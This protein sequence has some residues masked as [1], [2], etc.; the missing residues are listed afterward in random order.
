MAHLM[1]GSAT[2]VAGNAV[3]K[4]QP[5]GR[6]GNSG[7]TLEPHLHIGAKKNGAEV[8][9]LFDGRWLSLNSVMRT[10]GDAQR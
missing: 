7:Y 8:G 9:V 1:Q 6:V 5:L 3:A 4:K 2:V 10:G